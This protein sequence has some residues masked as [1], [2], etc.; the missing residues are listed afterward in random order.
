MFSVCIWVVRTLA[1]GCRLLVPLF[2]FSEALRVLIGCTAWGILPYSY[3]KSI[4]KSLCV[5][6][7]PL[8]VGSCIGCVGADLLGSR[9]WLI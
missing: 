7:L 3:P 1:G 2:P 6:A 8:W 9:P 4:H 5:L